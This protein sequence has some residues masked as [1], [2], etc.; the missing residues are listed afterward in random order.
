MQNLKYLLILLLISLMTTPLIAQ[1]PQRTAVAAVNGSLIFADEVHAELTRIEQQA[2][3]SGTLRQVPLDYSNIE[4]LTEHVLS[5]LIQKKLLLQEC[6][7][8]QITVSPADIAAYRTELQRQFSDPDQFSQHLQQQGISI[9]QLEKEITE[10]LLIDNLAEELLAQEHW[11]C[12][13]EE[14]HTYYKTHQ[15]RFIEPEQCRISEIIFSPGCSM[16]NAQKIQKQLKTTMDFTTGVSLY[17]VASSR[18]HA[19]DIG[20]IVV[21]RLPSSIQQELRS[22]APG[23]ITSVLETGSGSY[24]ILKLT[25][26]KAATTIPIEEAREHILLRLKEVRKSQIISELTNFLEQNSTIEYY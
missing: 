8:A 2:I 20:F 19:G 5:T 6:A 11:S 22:L 15:E 23:E 12:S 14:L 26:R 25:D 24:L 1:L 4:E 21:E 10:A 17:S 13:E 7:K 3:L 18:D 16:A 9:E